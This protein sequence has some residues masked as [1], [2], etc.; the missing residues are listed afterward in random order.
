VYAELTR[1]VAALGQPAHGVVA[2]PLKGD[3]RIACG[4]PDLGRYD[5]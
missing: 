1:S 3:D 4:W 5:R 2:K